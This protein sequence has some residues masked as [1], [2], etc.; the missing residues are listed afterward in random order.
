MAPR[1]WAKS[2]SGSATAR[3]R[4]GS[5]PPVVTLRKQDLTGAILKIT[6]DKVKTVCFVT[7]HGEK[8]LTDSSQQGYSNADAGLKKRKIT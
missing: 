4:V 2:S 3:P 6:T 1:A 7:G 5:R 8:S